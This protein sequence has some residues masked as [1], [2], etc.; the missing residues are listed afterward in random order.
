MSE[1]HNETR[2]E[3]AIG[4]LLH[5]QRLVAKLLRGEETRY[6]GDLTVARRGTRIIGEDPDGHPIQ[7]VEIEDREVPAIVAALD[8]RYDEWLKGL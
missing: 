4:D 2:Y 7:P 5:R 6:Y 3:V 8:N 1:T